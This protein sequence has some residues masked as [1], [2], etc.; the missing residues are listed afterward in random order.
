MGNG[1]R[2]VG[3]HLGLGF[4]SSPD[5]LEDHLLAYWHSF[6]GNQSRMTDK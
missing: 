3:Q 2:L 6:D 1:S 5:R 4:S